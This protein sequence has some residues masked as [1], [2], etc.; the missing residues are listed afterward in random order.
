MEAKQYA[1]PEEMREDLLLVC[2]NCFK[3]NPP[4]DPVHQHGKTL[5]VGISTDTSL[6]RKHTFLQLL[7]GA[8]LNTGRQFSFS[9]GIEMANK[10]FLLHLRHWL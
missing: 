4:S 6:V 5:Q 1:S 9:D 10:R 8:G 3:Y 7:C 2:E